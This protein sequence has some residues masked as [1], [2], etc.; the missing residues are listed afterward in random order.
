MRFKGLSFQNK[1][2]SFLIENKK[3]IREI[4]SGSFRKLLPKPKLNI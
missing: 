2:F 3:D 4:E 1:E